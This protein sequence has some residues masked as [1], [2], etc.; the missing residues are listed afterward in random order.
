[1][2]IRTII[3]AA[4]SVAA[5]PCRGDTPA[6]CPVIGQAAAA[7]RTTSAGAM[8]NGDWWPNQVNLA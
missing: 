5:I 1:M 3:A 6:S 8:T 4:L 2:T 7:G